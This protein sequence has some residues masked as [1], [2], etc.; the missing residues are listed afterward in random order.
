MIQLMSMMCPSGSRDLK[1]SIPLSSV[2]TR[3]RE[4]RVPCDACD[5]RV[6]RACPFGPFSTHTS[7]G[8]GTG[9]MGQDTSYS[10]KGK[11]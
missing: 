6:L 3:G 5:R 4:P 1:T 9:T 2:I 8:H 11:T 10:M 7:I